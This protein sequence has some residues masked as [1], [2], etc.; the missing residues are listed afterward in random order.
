MSDPQDLLY[1]NQFLSGNVLS[2]SQMTQEAQYYDRFKNYVDNGLID[3]TQKYVK[4]D[5]YENS[6]VNINKTN[7]TKWPVHKNKNHYP[8][9]DTLTNDISSN[10]YQKEIITKINIDSNNRDITAYPNSNSFTVPLNK[11][12]NNISKVI[13]NDIVLPNVNQS[14]TNS[15]NCLAWQYASQNSL[16]ELN[17]DNTI[18]PSPDPKRLIS[19][20][21]IPNSVFSYPSANG[22][23]PN[24]GNYLVYQ[25]NITPGFYSTDLLIS[26]IR[27]S[28]SQILHGDNY[29]N[30]GLQIIEQP[31]VAYP[32][33]IGTPHLF[34][35]YIDPLSSI[36]RFVNRMEEIHILAIQTFSPYNNNFIFSDIFYQNSSQYI[37]NPSYTLDTKYIYIIV[38]ASSDTT[39]QYYLNP[40]CIYTP[41]PF[42]LVITDLEVDVGNI[43]KRLINYTE[44]YDVQLYLQNGYSIDELSSV[45][46]YIFI[47]EIDLLTATS[48]TTLQNNTVTYLRFG[49][50][51][52]NGNVNSQKYNP[53]G[54]IIRPSTTNNIVFTNI[55][56][57]YISTRKYSSLTPTFATIPTTNNPPFPD[58]GQIITTDV[59]GA[60]IAASSIFPDGLQMIQSGVDQ[61]SGLPIYNFINKT[62]D[63]NSVSKFNSINGGFSIDSGFKSPAIFSDYLYI[64]KEVFIG[65]ALLFRWI[66]D[67]KDGL[68]VNYEFNTENEKK[69]SLL[70]ILA[71][72]IGNQ[73]DQ[74]YSIV[75]NDGFGFVKTN[76]QATI[77]N[78]PDLSKNHSNLNRGS[79][80][81]PS[82]SLRLQYFSNQYYFVNDP[83]VYIK[84]KFDSNQITD[85]TDQVINTT[86]TKQSEY[87]RLYIINDLFNVNIGEDHTCITNNN[88]DVTIYEKDESNIFAK[89]L[90]SNIPGNYDT[91][92]S[93]INMN[94]SYMIN[95]SNLLN[96]VANVS[97]EIYS[98]NFKLLRIQNN[99][100]FSLNIYE[101]KN[102]LKETLIDTKA[103]NVVTNGR[104]V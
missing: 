88:S 67:K 62:T 84:I 75:Q 104:I 37:N 1:T 54:S 43:E 26:N 25:A 4:E 16:L 35:T 44:F 82:Y 65:R 24:L 89:I 15:N 103:N 73:T 29:L 58:E 36:V 27:L 101:I 78:Q 5:D 60:G 12:F 38:P 99:F 47:D 34:K 74:V 81:I 28:T 55:I 56:D 71:W 86:S 72:P 33:R 66:F 45:S 59:S 41:N 91:I 39:S 42:P 32:K 19:Y 64:Q 40:N 31:Y 3:E 48:S 98:S 30:N 93:N 85:N 21:S 90:L 102:I 87:N 53:N 63:F 80:I 23:L 8:M 7:N 22:I 61:T 9:F 11:T 69:R 79:T 49:L 76:Y 68:Y 18:I 20:S 52:S 51:L 13:L 2:D 77:I 94:N 46:Y 70:R 17:I 95:Y 92:T 10:K 50:Q 14:V 96:N 57:A 100:S 6:H 83:Y 97:I